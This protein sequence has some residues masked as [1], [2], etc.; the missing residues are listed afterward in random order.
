[1]AINN[2]TE[3][4]INVNI[5]TKHIRIRRIKKSKILKTKIKKKNHRR[6]FDGNCPTV[7]VVNNIPH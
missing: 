7:L 2:Q 6:D 3:K 1:M 5:I 4:N